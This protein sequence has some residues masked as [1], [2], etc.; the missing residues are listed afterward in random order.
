[1]PARKRRALALVVVLQ[2]EPIDAGNAAA[3]QEVARPVGGAI[4][5][6]DDL[7]RLIG[8]L[9]YRLHDSADRFQLVVAGN[10]DRELHCASAFRK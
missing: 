3:L 9:A 7:L 5:D 4:V 2:D 1:M 10:D 8:R 6:D